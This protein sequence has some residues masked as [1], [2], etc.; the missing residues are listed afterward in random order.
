MK[1]PIRTYG[2]I[3]A[4]LRARISM[5]LD[6]EKIEQLVQARSLTEVLGLLR[7][8]PYEM[9]DEVYRKTGDLKIGELE[10]FKLEVRIYQ[11]MVRYT[12]GVLQRV[13]RALLIRYEIDTLK[14]AIR[15]FFDRKI[16]GR[17]VEAARLYIYR[18]KILH[19]FSIDEIIGANN[20]DG[21]TAALKKSPYAALVQEN[22]ESVEKDRSLFSLEIA[23]DRYYYQ[24]LLAETAHLSQTD[25][26]VVVRLIGVE[27]DLQNIYW[28]TRYAGYYD[29][30]SDRL[31]TL[32][33]PGG[34]NLRAD[35]IQD[36]LH[37]ENINHFLQNL[38]RG[39]YP[40][41]SMLLSSDTR[42]RTSRLLLIERLLEQILVSEVKKTLAGFP[43]TIG[44]ILSYYVLKRNEIRKIQ[45]ILNAKQYG[46][47]PDKIKGALS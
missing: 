24:N 36:A 34:H 20:V 14:N 45:T 10:L 43:F 33:V 21:I 25:R 13:V 41:I 39:N 6:E 17:S 18:E 23:F 22:W 42:D 40:D 30:S 8:T 37:A 44:I 3:N 47:S 35:T 28:I 4:K 27:I 32:V 15:L 16:R 26:R 19:D 46:I 31:Q 29:V 12:E 1:S 11:E 9:I 5:L 2:F 38:L 7:R